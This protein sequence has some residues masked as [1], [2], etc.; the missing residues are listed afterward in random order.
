MAKLVSTKTAAQLEQLIREAETESRPRG[1]LPRLTMVAVC[2]E[3]VGT[4]PRPF[5][6][7]TLRQMPDLS[8]PVT[9]DT[10]TPDTVYLA[11]LNGFVLTPGM[12][13]HCEAGGWVANE[14]ED[15]IV[16]TFWTNAIPTGPAPDAPE[17]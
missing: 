7:A 4:D 15:G 6:F 13:Y 3:E 17:T 2:G 1:R 10:A 5:Y 8:G 9:P 11:D 14:D 12:N 16:P